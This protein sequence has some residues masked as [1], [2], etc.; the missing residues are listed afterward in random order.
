MVGKVKVMSYKDIIE[1]QAKRDA[2]EAAVG[3]GKPDR[4]RKS[5]ALVEV[6]AKRVRKNE[7]EAVEGKI[8]AQG[9]ENYCSI[10][11]F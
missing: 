9:L 5:S 1:A 10:L 7:L 6:P 3:K 11:Q 8:K 4:K 2:K